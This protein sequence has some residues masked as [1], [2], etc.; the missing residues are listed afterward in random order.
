MKHSGKIEKIEAGCTATAYIAGGR[1]YVA[2]TIGDRTFETFSSLN[3][4]SEEI[5][6]IKLTE[7]SALLLSK[8]GEL[9]Q[10]G[11]HF[12][13]GDKLFTDTPKK[14]DKVAAIKQIYSGFNSF[15]ALSDGRGLLGWGDNSGGQVSS[16]AVRGMLTVPQTLRINTG[17]S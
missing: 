8:R 11:E 6:D 9:F 15:F 3:I 13:D 10:M 14:I 16:G 4:G 2:G 17:H 5:L 1:A 12:K 7:R